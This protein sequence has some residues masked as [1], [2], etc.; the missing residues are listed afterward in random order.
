MGRRCD[1]GGARGAALRLFTLVA[2]FTFTH[3]VDVGCGAACDCATTMGFT[4]KAEKKV[5][6]SP[7]PPPSPPPSPP[8]P[9]AAAGATKGDLAGSWGVE[10]FSAWKLD[11]K[12][13]A[14]VGT[15]AA[16]QGGVYSTPLTPVH[17][18]TLLESS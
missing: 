4:A 18:Y 2:L 10:A 1:A 17:L 7:P 11:V 5:C 15:L 13:S 16:Y 6:P 14:A 9:P 8:P 3:Q 12:A